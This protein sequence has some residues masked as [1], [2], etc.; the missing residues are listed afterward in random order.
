MSPE[1]PRDRP[2]SEP[3][4][5]LEEKWSRR[6]ALAVAAGG[7]VTAGALLILGFEAQRSQSGQNDAGKL[8]YREFVEQ[9]LESRMQCAYG[10]PE[11]HTRQLSE[12]SK[13]RMI[14][15]FKRSPL[16]DKIAR[17]TVR[18]FEENRRLGLVARDDLSE[19]LELGKFLSIPRVEIKDTA[20]MAS[21]ARSASGIS[22]SAR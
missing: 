17:D 15:G 5:T 19:Q 21:L 13:R 8:P 6:A 10:Y 4:E 22:R 9:F 12:T 14:E 20:F 7:L 2:M 16:Y 11:F 18:W 3:I 1:N